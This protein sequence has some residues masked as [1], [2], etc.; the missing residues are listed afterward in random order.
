MTPECTRGDPRCGFYLKPTPN[1]K[2][3]DVLTSNRIQNPFV[4]KTLFELY[5]LHVAN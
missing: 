4:H 1:L 2:Q 5:I 3:R